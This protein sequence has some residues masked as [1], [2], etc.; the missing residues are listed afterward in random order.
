MIRLLELPF[1]FSLSIDQIQ[2]DFQIMTINSTPVASF[3]TVS[4]HA[5]YQEVEIDRRMSAYRS[6]HLFDQSL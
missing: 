3:S 1:G 6:G 5:I 4:I 2:N